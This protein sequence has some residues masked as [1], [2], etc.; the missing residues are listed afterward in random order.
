MYNKTNKIILKMILSTRRFKLRMKLSK[1]IT[2]LKG[3]LL[4]D[5]IGRMIIFSKVSAEMDVSETTP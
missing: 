5:A 4:Q 1:L 3:Y 2:R